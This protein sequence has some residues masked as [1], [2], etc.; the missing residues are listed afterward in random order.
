M[1]IYKTLSG[2]LFDMSKDPAILFYTSDFLTGTFTM[3]D[4]QVGKYIR[5]LCLQHQKGSL[6]EK[7]MLN[8]CKSYDEDI[9]SKFI[10]NG[11][12]YYNERMKNEADRRK[13]Y[14]ESRSANRSQKEKETPKENN[15]SKSYVQHMETEIETSFIYS[16][17]YDLEIENSK[18]KPYEMVYEKAVQKIYGKTGIYG[19]CNKILK[20]KSQLTYDQFVFLAEKSIR[21]KLVLSDLFE[22]FDN[23]EGKYKPNSVFKSLSSWMDYEVQRQKGTANVR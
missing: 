22:K 6:T 2:Y 16:K 9:F 23:Y 11:S 18:G 4:D 19:K 8:I 17:F 14:S 13:K 3:T 12:G 21:I 1:N 5:L 15:I 10:K 7:D 20:M